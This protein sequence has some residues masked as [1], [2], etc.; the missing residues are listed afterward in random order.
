MRETG[1]DE[2][3]NSLETGN[4]SDED[5]SHCETLGTDDSSDVSYSDVSDVDA[6]D[7][8][9]YDSS[10]TSGGGASDEDSDASWMP[11]N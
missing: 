5:A 3:G 9:V 6:Y 7:S 1:V 4:S 10:S 8:D 11:S 2:T